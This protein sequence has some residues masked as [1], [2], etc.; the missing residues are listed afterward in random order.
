MNDWQQR[1]VDEKVSLEEK[2][3][4]LAAFFETETFE[5]LDPAEQYRM[6]AQFF[7]MDNYARVLDDRITHFSEQPADEI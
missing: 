2:M 4:K 1:V 7:A 6:H 3:K 5:A